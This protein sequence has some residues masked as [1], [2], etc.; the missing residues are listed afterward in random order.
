[1][2]R[3]NLINGI[4]LT[5]MNALFP[6]NYTDIDESCFNISLMLIEF[7]FLIYFSLLKWLLGSKSCRRARLMTF[8]RYLQKI[9]FPIL[10]QSSMWIMFGWLTRS[11][12]YIL[13]S[14]FVWLP[15]QLAYF[16]GPW[17]SRLPNELKCL[18]KNQG[19]PTLLFSWK[20]SV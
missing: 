18:V 13:I 16:P 5:L 19:T 7:V 8:S 17:W 12:S 2:F 3:P 11:A 20:F 10:G 4:S 15:C 1:M 14:M 9:K 6:P